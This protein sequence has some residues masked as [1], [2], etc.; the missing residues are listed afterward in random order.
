MSY[1]GHLQ[2]ERERERENRTK[3]REKRKEKGRI[4][5]KGKII[6]KHKSHHPHT[7][8]DFIRVY[9]AFTLILFLWNLNPKAYLR[10][11]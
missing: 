6:D 4:V 5:K 2:R 9:Q 7:L 1:I 3:R 8:G 10:K 11:S